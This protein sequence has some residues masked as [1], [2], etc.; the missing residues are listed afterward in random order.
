MDRTDR[1]LAVIS[2]LGLMAFTGVVVVFVR[3]LDLA[4]VVLLCLAMGANDF[5]RTFK[6]GA[7]P[8]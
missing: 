3:E 4:M 7:N 2:I 1:I 8:K 5:W 6:N